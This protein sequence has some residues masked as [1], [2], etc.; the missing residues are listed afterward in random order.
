MNAVVKMPHPGARP[1][2]YD[3]DALA[4]EFES[5]IEAT[6]VPIVAEFAARNGLHR[7]LL[8]GLARV[9]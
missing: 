7:Q 1:R 5:Y 8:Y 4:R 9:P 3:R 6:E 2:E